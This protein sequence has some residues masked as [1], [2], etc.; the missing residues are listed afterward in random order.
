MDRVDQVPSPLLLVQAPSRHS[1]VVVQ[2]TLLSL[3]DHGALQEEEV[4]PLNLVPLVPG[5][6]GHM[7]GHPHR[8]HME[9]QLLREECCPDIINHIFET[10]EIHFSVG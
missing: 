6:W 10:N 1:L 3:P 5:P 9:V 7:A 8:G 2:L 4:S